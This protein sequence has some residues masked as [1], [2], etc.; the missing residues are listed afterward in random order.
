[1][2]F[3]SLTTLLSLA[4]TAFGKIIYAGVNEVSFQNIPPQQSLMKIYFHLNSLV[5]NSVSSLL[6][7]RASVF[8][9][10]SESTSP[11]STR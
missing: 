6:V 8:L 3:G 9:G 1:M 7:K 2:F 5:V 10:A 4:S 11:S